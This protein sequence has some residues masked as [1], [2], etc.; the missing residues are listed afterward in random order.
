MVDI[1]RL[2]CQDYGLIITYQI[3]D[4]LGNADSGKAFSF[5]LIF[6]KNKNPVFSF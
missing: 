5:S 4:I 2:N 3:V 6:I 1:L